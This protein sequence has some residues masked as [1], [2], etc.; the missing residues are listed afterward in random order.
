MKRDGDRPQDVTEPLLAE[1]AA[2]LATGEPVRPQLPHGLRLHVDRPLPFL[3]VYRGPAEREDPGTGEFVLSEASFLVVPAHGA[4]RKGVTRLIETVA[5]AM[6]QRFGALL[7]VEIWSAGLSE[8]RKAVSE[9]DLEPTELRPAFRVVSSGPNSPLRT[10]ESLRTRLARI[11]YLRQSAQV[12]VEARGPDHP[13]ELPPLLSAARRKT[14]GCELVGLEVRPIYRDGL[15]G[16]LFPGVLRKLRQGVGR[17]LKQALFTFSK[18]RTTARP[19][20]FYSLGRRALV[21]GVKS[22][23]RQLSEVSDGFQ[24][25]L[26]VTPVNGEAA[27]RE[28]RRLRFDAVPTFYYRPLNVEV[29]DLKRRLYMTPIETIE[30]PTLAELFRQRQDEL[31]RKITMLADVG[32]PRFKLGSEQVYGRVEPSLYALAERLL[33]QLP[34]RSRA[35]VLAR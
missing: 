16:E 32:T 13:P 25:L 28:F 30:D 7:I 24:F 17:A 26:Q 11:T 5:Q 33:E 35:E 1:I 27:W 14:L 3:C 4:P 18:T 21:K 6:R 22:V 9:S 2:R 29:S 23:D 20:H 10:V 31:D 8:V 12:T 34:T 19:E 15:T